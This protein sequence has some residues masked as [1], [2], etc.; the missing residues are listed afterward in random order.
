MIERAVVLARGPLI[1]VEDLPSFGGDRPS[2]DSYLT[3]LM[4]LPLEQAVA[5]LERRLILRALARASGNKTEAARILGIHRQF[6]YTKL[7]DL[8]IE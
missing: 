3:E 4:E 2:D 8:G 6:L 5:S 7:R 1:T